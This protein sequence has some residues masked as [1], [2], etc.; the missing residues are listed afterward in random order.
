[1]LQAVARRLQGCA[2]RRDLVGRFGG[3][4]FVLLQAPAPQPQA[5]VALVQRIIE[6]INEPFDI[7]GRRVHASVSIGVA[8]LPETGAD[9]DQMLRRA[10]LALYE[11]KAGGRATWRLHE[12][13]MEARVQA[14]RA[15]A[16]DLRHAVARGE[17]ALLGP[18][19]GD[20]VA[21]ARSVAALGRRLAMAMTTEGGETLAA[22]VGEPAFP[23]AAPVSAAVAAVLG[24]AADDLAE[25]VPA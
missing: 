24:N 23:F 21:I 19:Q 22:C 5:A 16:M 9:L 1:M 3:D 11:A 25:P 14:R 13:A 20:G 10:D 6:K 12:T 17:R 15:L 4:E 8:L 7:D 18:Q 2:R